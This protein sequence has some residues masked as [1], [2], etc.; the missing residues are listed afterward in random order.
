[1]DRIVVKAKTNCL[2]SYRPTLKAEQVII[3][4]ALRNVPSV[5]CSVKY[6]TGLIHHRQ[7]TTELHTM[8]TAT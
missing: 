5:M 1:M 6:A 7:H 2:V 3:I 4:L 8:T